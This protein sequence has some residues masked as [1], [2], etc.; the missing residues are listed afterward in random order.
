V[1]PTGENA[2]I[3]GSGDIVTATPTVGGFD[4]VVF[5]SEGTVIVTTASAE[6]LEIDIDDNLL[7]YIEV[8]VASGTL[9]ISTQ[10]GVDIAPSRQPTYRIGMREIAGI[11]LAGAGSVSVDQVVG[12][13]FALGIHGV[14]DVTVDAIDVGMLEVRLDGVGSATLVGAAGHADITIGGVTKYQGSD[15]RCLTAGVR[16]SGTA[17]ATVWVTEQLDAI[18]SES[19]RISYYGPPG[20]ESDPN[21]PA[22]TS[23]GDK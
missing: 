13:D 11:D 18:A 8:A 16:A 14:G 2:G 23:L 12:A 20:L 6:S 5:R 7:Q 22:V 4:R 21:S 19:A 10:S 17:E 9:E 15:V 1:G 3:P